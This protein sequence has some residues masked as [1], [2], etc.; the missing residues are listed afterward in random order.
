MKT[1][2]LVLTLFSLLFRASYAQVSVVKGFPD[3]PN[4]VPALFEPLNNLILLVVLEK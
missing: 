1:R 4:S 3:N 2:L